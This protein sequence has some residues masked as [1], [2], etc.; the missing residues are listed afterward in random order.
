MSGTLWLYDFGRAV[1]ELADETSKKTDRTLAVMGQLISRGV[2]A[3]GAIKA[4]SRILPNILHEDEN[5]LGAIYGFSGLDSV[6]F[7][8]TDKRVVY[9]DKKFLF[10][11]TEDI[12][13]AAVSGV[14]FDW[15]LMSGTLILHTR[16]GDF[17]IRIFNKK[18]AQIFVSCIE[19]NCIEFDQR[20]IER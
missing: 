9:I 6:L 2:G 11:K 1:I 10:T 16:L 19:R 12:A 14:T 8:A 20:G 18:A 7:V 17:K 4:E 15:L 5:I 3:W 13:F